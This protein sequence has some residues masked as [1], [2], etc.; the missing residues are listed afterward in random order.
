[1][2]DIVIKKPAVYSPL[3][4][5]LGSFLGGPIAMVYFLW[6]NFHTLEKATAARNT[7]AF[8]FLFIVVLLVFTPMLPGELPGIAIQFVYSLVALQ[9]AV[10][11]QLRKDAITHSIRFSFQSNWRVLLFCI[12]LYFTWL[13]ICLLAARV[14]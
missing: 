11:W 6:D 9:M 14:S 3:Q 13:G 12:P 1:M 8:G 2:N 4:I 10:T 5:G 7:L